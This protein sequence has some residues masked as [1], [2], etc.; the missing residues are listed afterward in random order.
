MTAN[1]KQASVARVGK[2]SYEVR[3][4]ERAEQGKANRRLI[5][6]LSD[7]FKISKSKIKIIRGANSR[8]KIVEIEL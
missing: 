5:E 3:V 6:I 1:A 7:H 8:E 4:D 2:S